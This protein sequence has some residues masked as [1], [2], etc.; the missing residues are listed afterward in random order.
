MTTP[1]Y[2]EYMRVR[3]LLD[4]PVNPKRHDLDETQQAIERFRFGNPPRLDERTGRLVAG[5]GRRDTVARMEALGLEAPEGIVVDDTGEW[6]IPVV[7]GWASRDDDEAT[8][9]AIAD[10]RVGVEAGWDEAELAKALESLKGSD[11][12]L[13]GIGFDEADLSRMLDEMAGGAGV[14]AGAGGADP[15]DIPDEPSVAVSQPGDLW[16]LGDHQLFV[17]SCADAVRVFGSDVADLL[18]TD[19]PYGVDY[20]NKRR[21]ID[22]AMGRTNKKHAD[23][24]NDSHTP[25]E[26]E[27]LWTEW[28]TAFRPCLRPGAAY[29]VTGPQ[30]GELLLL[31]L[32]AMRASGFPLRHMIIWAKDNFVLGRSDYHYQH[33][34]IMYGWV[35]G[36]AHHAVEDRTQSS[37][38]QIPKP[39]SS[40]LH[41][42]MKP[43][44]LYVRAMQ[45]SSHRGN[46]VLEPFGGSGTGIIAGEQCGRAVRSCE[47]SPAYCDVIV[48]RWQGV[49]GKKATR[50]RAD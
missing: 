1:R 34:P 2:I 18:I 7:R 50:T 43:V 10:N 28:F 40:D 49:T 30:G 45:N 5:H 41:P 16:H 12:G 27:K 14:G 37:I 23:I 21:E 42:T 20:S 32:L 48:E 29:Y 9:A 15:D 17:G 19:P 4:A 31:L 33:E 3:D 8:A 25:E 11:G 26:M 6:R 13:D 24:A 36:A 22:A 35:E 44:E 38:W 46:I 47:L 39:R